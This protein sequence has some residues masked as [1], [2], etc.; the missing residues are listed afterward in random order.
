VDI[1]TRLTR[2]ERLQSDVFE[3]KSQVSGIDIR[4]GALYRRVEAAVSKL[5][6]LDMKVWKSNLDTIFD[7]TETRIIGAMVL[8]AIILTSV[9]AV[10]TTTI[11][12]RSVAKA[13]SKA[14]IRGSE[15][16]PSSS[17]AVEI[18]QHR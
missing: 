1:E 3:I 4:L 13:V 18:G 16:P 14:E 2:L 15:H 11:A 6:A 8:A 9:V 17:E 5:D 12:E 10:V 7:R